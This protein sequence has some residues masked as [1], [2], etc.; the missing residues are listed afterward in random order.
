MPSN[1]MRVVYSSD[2]SL[3]LRIGDE[4][5]IEAHRDILRLTPLLRNLRAVVNVHPAYASILIDFN[6]LESG[7]GDLMR[8]AVELYAQAAAA[9]L[10]APR[11]VE[12][13]VCYGGE[14]GPDLDDV[15]AIG[16]RTPEEVAAI[17]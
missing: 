9:P 10:P 17:H 11:T 6:P 1:A 15:A 5:S 8:V 16:G 2:R 4:I 13:P 3:L 12:I 14:Y 7:H